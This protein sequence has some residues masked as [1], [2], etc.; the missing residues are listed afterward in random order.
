MEEN[1]VNN[2]DPVS[3]EATVSGTFGHGWETLKKYFPEL[4]LIFFIVIIFSLPMGLTNAFN[5][6][7]SF[8]FLFFSLFNVAYGLVILAPL[9]YGANYLYLRAMRGEKF[10]V[11]EIFDAY[12]QTLQIILANILVFVVVG[13][14][15][16]LLIIPG[17]IFACKLSLVSYLVMDR[18]MEAVEAVRTSW[19]M[20][21][22][23][24]FTIFLMGLVSFFVALGGLI[25]LVVGIIPAAIWISLAFAGIYHAIATQVNSGNAPS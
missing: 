18:K 2:N 4:I 25:L 20:T 12:R 13:I 5:D 9:S 24:T 22:G 8:G 3:I 17:I 15:F 10:R 16:A 6:E 7:E 1:Q 21:K 11:Q 19:Q 14:G 23:H